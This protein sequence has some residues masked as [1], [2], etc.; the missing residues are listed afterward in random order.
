MSAQSSDLQLLSYDNS[1]CFDNSSTIII[2][3]VVI[4]C[5]KLGLRKLSLLFHHQNYVLDSELADL[6]GSKQLRLM[7][8]SFSF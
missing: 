8:F 2:Y 5:M 4:R 7:Q 6:L 3:S 1:C